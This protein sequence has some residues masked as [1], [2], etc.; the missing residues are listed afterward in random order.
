LPTKHTKSTKKDK[1]MKMNLIALAN[2]DDSRDARERIPTGLIGLANEY[3]IGADGWVRIAPYGTFPKEREAVQPDG[4]IKAE[5]YLQRLT[6]PAA[7]ALAAKGNSLWSKLKR[8]RRGIPIY[9][10]H[11]DLKKHAPMT[12]VVENSRGGGDKGAMQERG[13][14][15]DFEARPDGLYGRPVM[16]E[17][18]Q[19][20]VE[21]E[22]LKFISPLWWLRH[23]A[24]VNGVMVVEPMELISVGLVAHPNIPGGTALA[25]SKE[26]GAGSQESGVGEK[27]TQNQSMKKTIIE[28]L[29]L[30]GI[31]LANEADDAAIEA[32][33][34]SALEKARE[35]AT[36]A[37][38]LANERTTLSGQ[39]V[40]L[41]A[42][43][44]DLEGQLQAKD[45]AAGAELAAAKVA[46][47]NEKTARATAEEKAKA[48]R[49]A[50]IELALDQ[51]VQAGRITAAERPQW[52]LALANEGDFDAKAGELAAKGPVVKVAA[53]TA[54]LGARKVATTLGSGKAGQIVALAN[55]RLKDFEGDW[56]QAFASVRKS[57]PALFEKTAE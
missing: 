28:L 9:A 6:Q 43:V 23:I 35:N 48:E 27:Q 13:L 47:E 51:A 37:T 44:G 26:P 50:R 17:A 5:R 57:H 40:T 54:N 55:E 52:G 39:V 32:G 18:G 34:L 56:D 41:T 25:N 30:L 2:E 42:K 49:K 29:G 14:F 12:V 38:A 3:A 10:G 36:A 22:G 15:V 16:N 7:A 11:P 20:S 46:L 8:F 33:A 19:Q 45:T 4:T 24:A 21:R 1:T 31:A 53:V